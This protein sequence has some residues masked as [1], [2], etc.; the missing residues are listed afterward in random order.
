MYSDATQSYLMMSLRNVTCTS[1]D[2]TECGAAQL[3]RS[4]IDQRS[5]V[6]E[7]VRTGQRE[8]IQCTEKA[9]AKRNLWL[10]CKPIHKL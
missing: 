5:H 3:E 2:E 1:H 4:S 9:G 8:Q 10:V 7:T 6:S